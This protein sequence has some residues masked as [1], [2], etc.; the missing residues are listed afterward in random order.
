MAALTGCTRDE[1]IGSPFK[2]Y[3]ADPDRA[4]EGIRLV[5]REGNVTNYELTARSKGGRETVVSYNAAPPT[6]MVFRCTAV[7]TSPNRK[8][9]NCGCVIP[10]LT[11][12]A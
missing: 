2:N 9:W 6:G 10:R 8:N 12:E 11:T 3:F 5:L 7:R 4:E 1:L